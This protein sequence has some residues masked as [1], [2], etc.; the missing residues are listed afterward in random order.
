MLNRYFNKLRNKFTRIRT[1]IQHEKILKSIRTHKTRIKRLSGYK[2][3][4]L[5]CVHE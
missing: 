4:M 3:E 2:Y 1:N 5:L